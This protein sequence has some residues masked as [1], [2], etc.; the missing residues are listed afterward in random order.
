M[1]DTSFSW[2]VPN[3]MREHHIEEIPL[4][5][6]ESVLD[7][8]GLP[9]WECSRGEVLDARGFHLEANAPRCDL[10][11]TQCHVKATV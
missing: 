2:S 10:G 7:F 6:L 4:T 9:V 5:R 11:L 8:K 3:T 1:G